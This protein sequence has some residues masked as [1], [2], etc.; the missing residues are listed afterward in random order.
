M[1]SGLY[2]GIAMGITSHLLIET[3]KTFGLVETCR[4]YDI[5]IL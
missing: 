2:F 3:Y 4:D 1:N 5:P